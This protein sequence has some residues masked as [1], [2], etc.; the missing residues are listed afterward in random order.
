MHQ[1]VQ[2]SYLEFIGTCCS[3]RPRKTISVC[4]CIPANVSC[5]LWTWYYVKNVIQKVRRTNL[6]LS[7]FSLSL[8][9]SLLACVGHF[10]VAGRFVVALRFVW[11]FVTIFPCERTRPWGSLMYGSIFLSFLGLCKDIWGN[12]YV[13]QPAF[14]CMLRKCITT[15]NRYNFTSALAQVNQSTAPPMKPHNK[16][17]AIAILH[18]HGLEFPEDCAINDNWDVHCNVCGIWIQWQSWVGQCPPNYGV[19]HELRPH[20]VGCFIRI[21]ACKV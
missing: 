19:P 2:I 5:K 20:H 15:R 13:F 1:W 10:V 9:L 21:H 17:H 18:S 14:E 8:S 3:A 4:V 7:S 11:F 12:I 16:E 6:Y